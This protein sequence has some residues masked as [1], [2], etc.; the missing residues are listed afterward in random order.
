[1]H[2]LIELNRAYCAGEI[3]LDEILEDL[4]SNSRELFIEVPDVPQTKRADSPVRVA[5][6]HQTVI[7]E[8]SV[9]EPPPAA[10]EAQKIIETTKWMTDHTTHPYDDF[11]NIPPLS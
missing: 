4:R 10:Q 2:P 6:V 8:L 3:T 7:E 5:Q 9:D 11:G 1:M